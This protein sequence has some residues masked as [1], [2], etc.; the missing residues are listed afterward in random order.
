MVV[1]VPVIYLY[2]YIWFLV[3]NQYEIIKE[4]CKSLERMILLKW[5]FI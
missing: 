5:M 1:I 4:T 3:K 2:V